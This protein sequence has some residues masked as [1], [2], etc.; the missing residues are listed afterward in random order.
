MSLR[1][2]I[3]PGFRSAMITT[4]FA[5]FVTNTLKVLH[6]KGETINVS[7]IATLYYIKYVCCVGGKS[8]G[9]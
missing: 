6:K 1:P 9:D 3:F 2:G 8:Q 4:Y 5:Y 7:H